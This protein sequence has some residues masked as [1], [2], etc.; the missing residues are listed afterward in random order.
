[1][2]KDTNRLNVVIAE[3]KRTEKW[4]AKTIRKD[5]SPFL[6]ILNLKHF[7]NIVSVHEINVKIIINSSKRGCD[8]YSSNEIKVY[9]IKV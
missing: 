8:I 2:A 1:M 4:L 6:F 5:L 3:K 9:T 7:L